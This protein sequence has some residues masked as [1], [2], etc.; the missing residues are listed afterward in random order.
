MYGA[1]WLDS[2]KKK[3]EGGGCVQARASDWLAFTSV[4]PWPLIYTFGPREPFNPRGRSTFT[5]SLLIW[6]ADEGR[7]GG[8][9]INDY[10]TWQRTDYGQIIWRLLLLFSLLANTSSG[11]TLNTPPPSSP[12]FYPPFLCLSASLFKWQR[13][14]ALRSRARLICGINE[15]TWFFFVKK[16][17]REGGKK[18]EEKMVQRLWIVALFA[19]LTE[20]CFPFGSV[21][22]IPGGCWGG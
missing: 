6:Q 12:P 22:T 7:V 1:S 3:G 2:R 13:N 11:I 5:V 17:P 19:C 16:P 15:T 10:E 21:S 18:K 4:P 9:V 14:N 20:T 8:G